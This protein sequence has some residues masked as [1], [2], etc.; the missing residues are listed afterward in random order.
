VAE[1][2]KI[3]SFSNLTPTTLI[4][5]H[6][7]RDGKNHSLL[8]KLKTWRK[9][10]IVLKDFTTVLELRRESRQ[11]ILSQI[12]EISDGYLSKSFGNDQDVTWSGRLAI[13]AGVTPVIDRHHSISQILGE[14]FITY[15]MES[16][17]TRRKATKAIYVV[18]KEKSMRLELEQMTKD[19]LQQ[20]K[21]SEVRGYS[22]FYA[23]SGEII[24]PQLF[25]CG[26]QDS[27]VEG[28]IH[29]DD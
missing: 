10:I 26:G 19:F 22:H 14:R 1:H 24:K 9:E 25:C 7:S 20:L 5:G 23:N 6:K 21:K 13:I 29:S 3:F 27:C 15:R 17:D 18:G 12:R 2:P 28:P 4:S 8:L 11:E 16:D